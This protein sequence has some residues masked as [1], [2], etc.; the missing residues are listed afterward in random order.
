[1]PDAL[2]PLPTRQPDAFAVSIAGS[3]PAAKRNR[4][5]ANQRARWPRDAW[6]HVQY[7]A[8]YFFGK[9]MKT[10][11]LAFI[12][13]FVGLVGCAPDQ[14]DFKY[15]AKK[16][17]IKVTILS[18]E[19][20]P[21]K[22]EYGSPQL[23]VTGVAQEKQPFPVKQYDLHVVYEARFGTEKSYRAGATVEMKDGKGPF[24]GSIYL[25]DFPAAAKDKPVSFVMTE[26]AWFP[27]TS[28]DVEIET[29]AK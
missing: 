25:S 4:Q 5:Q 12:P 14:G 7:D 11:I 22:S 9:I 3:R 8:H 17:A 10:H 28:A 20:E 2:G 13:L 26:A 24:E 21:A 6:Q 27:K 15:I 1:M 19:V 18:H 23:K 29:Q 16:P